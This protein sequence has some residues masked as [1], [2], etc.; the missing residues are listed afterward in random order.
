MQQTVDVI[1]NGAGP[2]GL[3]C[4]YLL[5]EEGLS[6]YL[7]DKKTGPTEQ[8]RALLVTPRSMD[9]LQHHGLAYRILEHCLV[10]RG[11]LLH[12]DGFDIGK[13]HFGESDCVFPQVTYLTQSSMESILVEEVEK[14]P[15]AVIHWQTELMSY[16]QHG[17]HVQAH[18]TTGQDESI[19]II[20]KY[21]VGADG[22]HSTVRK[23]DPTWSYDGRAITSQFTLADITVDGSDV[24]KIK[25]RQVIY[26]HT[27]GACILLPLPRKDNDGK[28]SV[29]MV[30]NTGSYDTDNGSRITHGVNY[31]GKVLT[32]DMVNEIMKERL[33]GLDIGATSAIWLTYFNVNERMANGFRRGRAFVIGDAAHCHSP[34]GGQGMNIGFHDAENLAWKLSLVV[35]GASSDPEKVLDSFSLERIPAVKQVI[36]NTSTVMKIVLGQSY[37]MSLMRFAAIITT[38]AF[39]SLGRN[40]ARRFLQVDIKIEESKILAQPGPDSLIQPGSFLKDTHVLLNKDVSGGV[41]R[42]TVYQLLEGMSKTHIVFWMLTRQ[43]W[44]EEPDITQAFLDG[45]AKYTSCRGVVV[46]S[47]GQSDKYG[48]P[49]WIDTRAL[50]SSE[51]LTS[52]VGLTSTLI[53]SKSP[54]PPAAL[55]VL[56][57][58]RYVAYSGLVGTK[59]ELDAAFTFLD[60]YLL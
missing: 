23:Q 33:P 41:K 57:P 49:G 45:I 18:Y 16:E 9:I 32:L 55:V 43:I 26:Y 11:A 50:T 3:L 37:I 35:K 47:A 1:V 39:P 24:P 28:T 29:R 42:Q 5:M 13:V 31:S 8:S 53:S 2:V 58:D 25:N 51:S 10:V 48:T 36:N 38:K 46:Q 59:L 54:C 6:V 22:C 12:V 19:H 15:G 44:Q 4:A 40:Y 17:D 34:A 56:R 52:R 30:A 14:L 7:A 21:I 27:K 60:S 20:A